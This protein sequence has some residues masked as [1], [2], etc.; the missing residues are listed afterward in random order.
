MKKFLLSFLFISIFLL[1]DAYFVSSNNKKI[2]QEDD[3][4]RFIYISYLEYLI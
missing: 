1:S 2:I 4:I 3:N